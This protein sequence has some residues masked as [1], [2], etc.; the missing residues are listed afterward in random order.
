MYN[1][2]HYRLF[3]KYRKRSATMLKLHRISLPT[4]PIPTS[5][6]FILNCVIPIYV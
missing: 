3:I 2:Q 6:K 5:Q 1:S 4:V